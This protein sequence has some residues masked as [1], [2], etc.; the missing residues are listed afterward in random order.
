MTA[1]PI[2][3]VMKEYS[4][5][6]S[7]PAAQSILIGILPFGS[8]FGSLITQFMFKCTRRLT[9]IYI[10]TLVNVGAVVLINITMFATLVV[11]RFI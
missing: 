5:T 6:M 9:G 8:M 4:I 1:V 7:E 10:F 3:T 2:E 11:G